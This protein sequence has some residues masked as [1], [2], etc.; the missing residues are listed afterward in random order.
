VTLEQWSRAAPI[1]EAA[2]A[3]DARVRAAFV[4]EACGGD[5]ILGDEVQALLAGEALIDD[6]LNGVAAD[7]TVQD[8]DEIVAVGGRIGPY[9]IVSRI[10]SGGM[11]DVYRAVDSNLNREVAIKLLPHTFTADLNR[12]ARFVREAQMLA[13]LNH[14]RIGAI[15]G[16]ERMDGVPALILEL[17]EGPTLAERI[18]GRRLEVDEAV[19]IAIAIA[20]ALAAAHDRGIIHRDIKPANVKITPAGVKVLDFGLA[21]EAG[22][23]DGPTESTAGAPARELS[24]PGALLGTVAYMSPEQARGE[25]IDSRSDL[26]S[27][28][29]VLFEMVTGQPAFVG[30]DAAEILR[31][32]L[33]ERPPSPRFI[34]PAVPQTL[35]RV[36]ARLLEPE[37]AARYQTASAVRADLA[38]VAAGARTSRAT[39]SRTAA[40]LAV[41]ALAA[42]AAW[43]WLRLPPRTPARAEYTQI[44]SFSDSATSPSLSPDGRVLAFIRGE[45]TFE[46]PG[47]IYLKEL[48]D[49]Q[50][51][52]LTND[53]SDKMSPV[54]SPDGSR[55][56]YTSISDRFVWDTWMIPLEGRVPHPWLANASG[57]TWIGSRSVLFSAITTGLHMN[58]VSSDDTRGS[59]RLVY[60]PKPSEGMAHRSYLSPDRKWVLLAEML[61]P[62]WQPCRL[63]AIDGGA[64]RRVGPEGQCTYAAWSPDGNWMY[65]SSNSTGSFHLWRQRFPD[66]RPEQ[67]SF[68][69]GEEEGVAL[70]PDG[71]SVLTSIG[72]RQSSIW[73]RDASGER[74]VST[75]GYAFFPAVPNAGSAQPFSPDGRLLYLV[76]RG[77][78]KYS[79]PGERV[80]ELWQIDL[81]TSRSE[82]LLPGTSVTGYA[83][84]RDGSQIAF[85]ALDDRG[86]SHIWLWP[87]DRRTAPRQLSTME[88]DSPRFGANGNVYFRV[89]DGG[90]SFIYR[91]SAG[92]EA[93][94]A[95]DRPAAFLLSV[96]PDG[97]WLV[98]RVQAVPGSDSTQEN[99]AFST[100]GEPT[101]RLCDAM[102]E[103]DWTPDA[104]SLVLRVGGGTW[105]PRGRTFVIALRPGEPFPRLPPE[106]VRS[107]TDL[108]GLRILQVV[109]GAAYPG[110]AAHAIAFVRSTTQR[111]IFR[112]PLP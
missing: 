36:I 57:L 69:P 91:V 26:F 47:Q 100:R 15:Y 4:E 101:I 108:A 30:A 27:L 43:A 112:I 46:G 67:I 94:K 2:L 96:S 76:R 19:A 33:H 20:E 66:G 95:V 109:E 84:A 38:R 60:D 106:G 74:E 62:A 18:A 73:V 107:E 22:R 99:L 29:A 25:T 78:V 81:Q 104:A 103:I 61:R 90:S 89:T 53:G 55:I 86:R 37:R 64:N 110:D 35:E 51:V 11:G 23:R 3:K 70:T 17:V 85:A 13:A 9:I 58:L 63:V 42:M 83:V 14:P 98:A 59:P 77:A 7:L 82:A 49:G 32:V 6:F 40:L 97:A 24:N 28:G 102:C 44:T 31:A 48:P 93:T 111:N 79:G 5:A 16:L 39:Q 72:N 105:S 68:G 41:T 52:Q 8:S 45:S 54:F 34:N 50:P 12:I 65:F 92:G 87:T 75:E 56:A 1:L 80:G 10:G 71:R 21:K 88:G